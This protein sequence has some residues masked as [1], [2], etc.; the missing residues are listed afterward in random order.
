MTA[1]TTAPTRRLKIISCQQITTGPGKDGRPDWTLYAV[2]AFDRHGKRVVEELRSF[3]PLEPGK[4]DEFAVERR[5]HERYGTSFLLKRV[6]G[7]VGDRVAEL[8][9]QVA[10]HEKRIAEL[11]AAPPY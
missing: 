11:E 10:G 7:K 9:R 2:D 4:E 3:D 1:T 8:E 5:D 6:R